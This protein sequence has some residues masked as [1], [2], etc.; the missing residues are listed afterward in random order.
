[1][2]TRGWQ[3]RTERSAVGGRAGDQLAEVDHPSDGLSGSDVVGADDEGELRRP[4]RSIDE[5]GLG[6]VVGD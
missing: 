2:E 6:V 5:I 3:L 1:M 4:V